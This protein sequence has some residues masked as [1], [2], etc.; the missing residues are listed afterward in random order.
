[1]SSNELEVRSIEAAKH[2]PILVYAELSQIY[3]HLILFHVVNVFENKI[4]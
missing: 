3:L 2:F 1:M 4:I